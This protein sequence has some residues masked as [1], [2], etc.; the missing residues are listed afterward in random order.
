VGVASDDDLLVAT[1]VEPVSGEEIVRRINRHCPRGMRFFRA[2]PLRRG[3]RP[4]P[5][6]ACYALRVAP[7]RLEPLRRSLGAFLAA[8]RWPVE[9]LTPAKPKGRP[10]ATR[11]VDLKPRV[12]QLTLDAQ[13]L[14]WTLVGHRQVWARPSELLEA[15]GL[16]GQV[17][18]AAVRRTAVAYA[19]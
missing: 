16:D 6:A 12:T 14:R 9:R 1:L 15:L 18:L 3:Q 10:P 7:D 11:T 17:D 5:Q 2:R 19:L 8:E 4:Q 13:D